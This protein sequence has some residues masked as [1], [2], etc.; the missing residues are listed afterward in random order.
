MGPTLL[1][2]IVR[3]GEIKEEEG[4]EEEEEKEEEEEVEEEVR[5]TLFNGVGVRNWE[6]VDD[7]AEEVEE[8]GGDGQVR[9]DRMMHD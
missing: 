4:E 7:S 3:N 8:S 1:D 2:S 5:P 6:V 9:P